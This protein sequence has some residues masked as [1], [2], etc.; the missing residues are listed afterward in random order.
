MSKTISISEFDTKTAISD[1]PSRYIIPCNSEIKNNIDSSKYNI[2]LEQILDNPGNCYFDFINDKNKDNYKNKTIPNTYDIPCHA[3]VVIKGKQTVLEN[4]GHSKLCRL[5]T[6]DIPPLFTP[7][8]SNIDYKKYEFKQNFLINPPC[9]PNYSGFRQTLKYAD[10]KKFIDVCLKN[11][12]DGSPFSVEADG[13]PRC[14]YQRS[15][16]YYINE[17]EDE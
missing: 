10:N 16:S 17:E 2:K 14:D 3:L 12:R 9:P 1:N 6:S 4:D 11:C 13:E 15:G 8:P 7:S 5:T